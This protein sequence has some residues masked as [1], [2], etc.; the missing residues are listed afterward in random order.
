MR[1]LPCPALDTQSRCAD[2]LRLNLLRRRAFASQDKL[3]W[4]GRLGWPRWIRETAVFRD[5][6][7]EVLGRFL[8]IARNAAE[9]LA[10]GFRFS[11]LVLALEVGEAVSVKAGADRNESSDCHA[12]LQSAAF[13]HIPRSGHLCR[14]TGHELE[15]RCGNEPIGRQRRQAENGVLLRRR[16][17]ADLWRYEKI[18]RRESVKVWGEAALIAL[19]PRH[20]RIMRLSRQEV[21]QE[22]L[23][24]RRVDTCAQA[25]ES[26]AANG[27]SETGVVG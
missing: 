26:V 4:L 19:A 6:G 2:A 9:A 27:M 20:P 1:P 16:G 3:G 10:I 21:I 8:R 7:I 22:L 24:R 17:S 11:R 13:F 12:L 18:A 5:L 23:E 25:A 15:K 14:S